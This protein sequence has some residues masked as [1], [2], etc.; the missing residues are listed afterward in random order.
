MTFTGRL[1]RGRIGSLLLGAC[2][3]ALPASALADVT[4]PAAELTPAQTEQCVTM[5]SGFPD[6]SVESRYIFFRLGQELAK[7]VTPELARLMADYMAEN[8]ARRLPADWPM[9][10]VVEDIADPVL[11]QA[12]PAQTVAGMAHIAYFDALCGDFVAGQVNSLS[13][14]DP[15]LA[16][17]DVIIRE[18]ALYLRQIL[19][20]ALD[21][22]GAGDSAALQAYTRSLVT[23]RD[24]IEFVGFED[25]VGELEALFMGDLDQ[26]LAKSNDLVNEQVDVEGFQDA[27]QLSRDM[28]A[29]ARKRAQKERLYSLYRIMGGR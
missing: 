25:E 9:I 8:E 15:A 17:A 1:G 21:R 29:E 16:D 12:A 22:L 4:I 7:D 10:D 20:E 6:D 14:Y 5:M 28:N 13:A 3:L 26:K 11:R 23:E 24:D 27:A 19:A 18:D 2:A